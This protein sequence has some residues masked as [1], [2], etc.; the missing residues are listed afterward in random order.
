MTFQNSNSRT[1]HER[2]NQSS[3]SGLPIGDVFV[4]PLPTY[5]A[6][7]ASRNLVSEFLN[8]EMPL[9]LDSKLSD[10]GFEKVSDYEFWAPRLCGI[11]CI[12][13]IIDAHHPNST[14]TVRELTEKAV[15]S[16]G[17]IVHDDSGKLVD[18]GWYYQPLINL[19]SNYGFDGTVYSE[20]LPKQICELINDNMYVIASVHPGVIRFDFE[21]KP[22]GSSGGHLVVVSGF[23]WDGK[24]CSGFFVYNSSARTVETQ[25]NAF[26]PYGRFEEAFAGRGFA[27]KKI[28]N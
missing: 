16:K 20:L 1:I 14:E 23:R 27:V 19:L 12:K 10:F 13:M 24:K 4:S 9:S 25:E 17:Y 5:S 15:S 28:K 2:L 3:L 26:V 18:T 7:F 11:I 8:N 6:Q 22:E 21:K